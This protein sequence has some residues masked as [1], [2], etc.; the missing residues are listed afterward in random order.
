MPRAGRLEAAVCARTDHGAVFENGATERLRFA[1]AVE[2]CRLVNDRLAFGVVAGTV[3]AVVFGVVE[4][5]NQIARD[6]PALL[7]GVATLMLVVGLFS[8]VVP[9]LRG[10]RIQPTEALRQR[11]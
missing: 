9:V 1:R 4:T 10:L 7:A 5:D 3:A 6:W 2:A 8:C 11:G